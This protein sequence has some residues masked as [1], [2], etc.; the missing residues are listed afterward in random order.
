MFMHANNRPTFDGAMPRD[1]AKLAELGVLGPDIILVHM[2]CTA[3]DEWEM[4]GR[5]GGH[6]CYTPETEYQMGLGWPNVSAPRAIRGGFWVV[7]VFDS[8]VGRAGVEP[9]TNGLKVHH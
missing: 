9:A 1:V 8:L 3:P 7:Q 5:A 2:C 4:L 6:V